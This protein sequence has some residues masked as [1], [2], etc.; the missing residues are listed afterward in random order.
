M[1][2][3]RRL[4]FDKIKKLQ[5]NPARHGPEKFLARE[6]DRHTSDF[7]NDQTLGI[8]VVI[9][10]PAAGINHGFHK[11][12]RLNQLRIKFLF[13]TIH[14]QGECLELCYALVICVFL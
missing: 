11:N 4:F 8:I 2:I 5:S 13:I 14:P 10:N 6:G 9:L 7:V 3:R 1:L 12:N